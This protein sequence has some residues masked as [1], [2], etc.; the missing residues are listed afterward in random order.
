MKTFMRLTRGTANQYSVPMLKQINTLSL[1]SLRGLLGL[2]LLL[3]L[4]V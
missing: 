2:A 4:R 1:Y 3:L